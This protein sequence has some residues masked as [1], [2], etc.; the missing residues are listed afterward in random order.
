MSLKLVAA[1]E[2][3]MALPDYIAEAYSDA[4][5]R[6]CSERRITDEKAVRELALVEETAQRIHLALARAQQTKQK[7]NDV[8]NQ[9]H[10]HLEGIV[11]VC[12]YRSLIP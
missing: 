12:K 4:L 11:N 10:N 9:N 5:A 7:T 8:I 6:Y 3:R 2:T 1:P